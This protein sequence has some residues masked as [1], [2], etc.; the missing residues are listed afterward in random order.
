MVVNVNHLHHKRAVFES[1]TAYVKQDVIFGT[2]AKLDPS[3]N[4]QEMLP[5]VYQKNCFINFRNRHGG[6]TFIAIKNCYTATE[7]Q[8]DTHATHRDVVWVK[9]SISGEKTLYLCSF[10][11]AP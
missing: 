11:R 9:V 3:T 2:E 1:C 10:F 7:I 8:L 4:I 5:P 6:G